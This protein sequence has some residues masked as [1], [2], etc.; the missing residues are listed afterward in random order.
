MT[1]TEHSIEQRPQR[2][3]SKVAVVRCWCPTC[4]E[5]TEV[6]QGE[7]TCTR[8]NRAVATFERRPERDGR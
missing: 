1:R 5:N 7:M 4:L 2:V 3:T 8:C 6:R